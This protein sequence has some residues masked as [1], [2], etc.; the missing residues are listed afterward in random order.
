M[1]RS[2]VGPA[3]LTSAPLF[4]TKPEPDESE[5]HQDGSGYNQP[6]A[7][8]PSLRWRPSF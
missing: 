5:H 7:G 3:G 6:I 4:L 1:T 2:S 8:I